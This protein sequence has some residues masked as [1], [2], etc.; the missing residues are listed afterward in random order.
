ML[1]RACGAASRGPSP[2][3]LQLQRDPLRP[4]RA[5]LGSGCAL[6]VPGLSHGLLAAASRAESLGKVPSCSPDPHSGA[7][8][9]RVSSI[10][11]ALPGFTPLR[12]SRV[13][14][15]ALLHGEPVFTLLP[16]AS[17]VPPHPP[18]APPADSGSELA[19]PFPSVFWPPAASLSCK[20]GPPQVA[21][22]SPPDRL[23]ALSVTLVSPRTPKGPG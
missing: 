6:S 19:P 22:A 14:R 1:E 7:P 21:L 2:V 13:C 10:S 17:S 9:P 11:A 4:G 15:L 16:A 8:T 23:P 5:S 12:P 3:G 20:C 18:L